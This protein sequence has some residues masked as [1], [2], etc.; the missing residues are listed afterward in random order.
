MPVI[1]PCPITASRHSKQCLEYTHLH[2]LNPC[3]SPSFFCIYCYSPMPAPKILFTILFL[4]FWS[5]RAQWVVIFFYFFSHGNNNFYKTNKSAKSW[6]FIDPQLFQLKCYPWQENSE[7]WARLIWGI[8]ALLNLD[9]GMWQPPVSWQL[10][11]SPLQLLKET[12]SNRNI[13]FIAPQQNLGN[14][15][16][17]RTVFRN[18]I[19][20]Q[21]GLKPHLK[22]TTFPANQKRCVSVSSNYYTFCYFF[23][24]QRFQTSSAP[25]EKCQCTHRKNQKA[26]IKQQECLLCQVLEYEI[27]HLPL[28]S[29]QCFSCVGAAK[30][31]LSSVTHQPHHHWY[32][33]A[34]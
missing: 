3:F 31:V 27:Q 26:G 21:Y 1:S 19:L 11:P 15:Q 18:L 30:L 13:N 8:C 33:A 24:K 4:F 17:I 23:I 28:P 5:M 20:I 10:C 9:P 25:E 22:I 14:L 32:C 7:E 29:P 34:A 2:L 6:W 16:F 12:R